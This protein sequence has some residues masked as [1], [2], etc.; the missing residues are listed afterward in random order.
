MPQKKAKAAD[1]S[2]VGEPARFASKHQYASRLLS[3]Y[4]AAND[5]TSLILNYL[6]ECYVDSQGSF[7][8]HCRL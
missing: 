2:V 1:M 4:L 5:E 3:A 8:L 7:Q 6:R